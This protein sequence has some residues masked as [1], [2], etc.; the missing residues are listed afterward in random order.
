V[1]RTYEL[2]EGWD[3]A[4]AVVRSSFRTFCRAVSAGWDS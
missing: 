3:E 1:L 4:E 2:I